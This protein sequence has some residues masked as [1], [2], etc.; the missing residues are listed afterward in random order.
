MF[1]NLSFGSFE[2]LVIMLLYNKLYF[3]YD[4]R[5]FTDYTFTCY[6]FF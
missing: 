1:N 5:D 3:E 2:Y 4:K 6:F